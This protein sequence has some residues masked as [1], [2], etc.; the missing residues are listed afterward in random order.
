MSAFTTQLGQFEWNVMPFGM[1]NAPSTFQRHIA[2]ILRT[3]ITQGYVVQF[4]DDICIH[5]KTLDDHFSHVATVLDLLTAH[6]LRTKLSKCSFFQTKVDFLGH[7]ISGDGISVDPAKT[8]AIDEWPSPKDAHELRSFL[9]LANYYSRFINSY[10]DICI[11]LFPLL[12][13]DTLWVWGAP[14]DAAFR[15]L[16]DCLTHAPVLACYRDPTDKPTL[17]TVLVT[18]ASKFA[19]GGVLMQG[20]GTDLRPIAFY[21]RKFANAERNYTTREQELLAIKACL[22]NWLCEDALFQEQSSKQG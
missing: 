9:G 8:T 17:R 5:S 13:K 4:I 7:V 21:S 14:Q 2:L 15:T 6:H 20:E 11:P 18:D 12:A 10:A 3:C 16:Q 1:C 22:A 19:L